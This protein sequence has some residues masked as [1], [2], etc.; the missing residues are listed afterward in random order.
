VPSFRTAEVI[1]ILEQRAGLQRV[2]VRF[3]GAGSHGD[4][5][6]CLTR[7]IGAVA[8]GDRVVLNTTAVELGLGTGGWHVVHW[9]LSHDEVLQPGP[10]HVMKLRYTSLQTDAGTDELSFPDLPERIDGVPVVACTVHSQVA[11]VAAAIKAIRPTCNLAYVMTDGG[12]LPIALSDLVAEL[13][14]RGLLDTTVTTGDA[15][16]GDLEAVTPASGL[17]LARHAARADVIVAGMGPGVVGT[18]TTY[19]TTAIEVGPLLD[20]VAHLGGEPVLCIRASEG[21]GRDRHRGVSHHTRTVIAM[22]SARPWVAP[23]P[24]EVAALD[25]VRVRSVDPPRAVDVLEASGMHVTTMGR[26]IAD[27]PLF[28]ESAVAAGALAVALAPSS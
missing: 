8:P 3:E 14:D 19:G 28:F 18:G 16:G 6:Y 5:A 25:G 2:R 10:D 27:D 7:Q 15:F 9:N 1:E 24:P 13:R 21:D 12:A 22:S 17:L 26:T 11:V 23:V 4:R 20:V